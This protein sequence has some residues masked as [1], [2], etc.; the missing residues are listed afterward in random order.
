MSLYA[1]K[2][3]AYKKNAHLFTNVSFGKPLHWKLLNTLYCFYYIDPT[4]AGKENLDEMGGSWNFFQSSI[5]DE[6]RQKK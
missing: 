3:D 4:A 6:S 1:Y 2:C 5:V